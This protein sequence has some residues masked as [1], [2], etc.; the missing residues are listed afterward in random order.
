LA[1]SF[2]GAKIRLDKIDQRNNKPH[3]KHLTS[4]EKI[5]VKAYEQVYQ[6]E[7]SMAR[8]ERLNPDWRKTEDGM[9][10]LEIYCKAIDKKMKL[11]DK[12]GF[13]T[14]TEEAQLFNSCHTSRFYGG[15]F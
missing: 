7:I 3:Y 1:K 10:L 14:E 5:F 6:C 13:T 8:I 9:N 4:Q 15:S 11:S 12:L 2:L